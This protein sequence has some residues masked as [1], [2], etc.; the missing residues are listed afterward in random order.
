M[1][2]HMIHGLRADQAI[3]G[4]AEKEQGNGVHGE[5]LN[6]PVHEEGKQD[7]FSTFA[8][9]NDLCKINLDHDGVHHKKQAEGN[10]DRDYRR[11]PNVNG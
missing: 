9:L 1:H 6:S 5:G 10:G 2:F 4:C 8:G 11:F 7:G 3:K